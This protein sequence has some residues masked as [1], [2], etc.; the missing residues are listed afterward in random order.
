MNDTFKILV[1]NL[2]IFF[3]LCASL[4]SPTLAYAGE[5]I[6]TVE[7]GQPAPFDGTLFNTEAAARLLVDLE[8]SQEACQIETTRQLQ[9]Q[10]AQFHL[11]IDVLQASK[12][13]LQFRFDETL[14]IRNDHILYLEKKV[15]KPKIPGEVIFA[16]GVLSGVALTIGAGYA[17]GQAA[18]P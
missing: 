17:I 8:F 18:N 6:A 13:S 7:E 1:G 16:I 10:A 15:T 3:F 2:T 4:I 9:L 11:E 12:D 5:E 14:A